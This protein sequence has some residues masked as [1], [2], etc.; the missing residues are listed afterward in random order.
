MN[1]Y[2]GMMKTKN[3]RETTGKFV[4]RVLG[5][6]VR[7]LEWNP[8]KACFRLKGKYKLKSVLERKYRVRL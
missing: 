6:F 1:T 2:V 7:Y 4:E 8:Q 5:A 3:M